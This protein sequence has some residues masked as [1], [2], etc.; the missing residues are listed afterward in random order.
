[1]RSSNYR[2]SQMDIYCSFYWTFSFTLRTKLLYGMLNELI[3]ALVL[4]TSDTK[5]GECVVKIWVP[6]GMVG[7]VPSPAGHV[8]ATP[9]IHAFTF[10]NT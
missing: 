6:Y 8:P 10:H 3:I 9:P 1:M 7:P 4:I 5:P 2:S